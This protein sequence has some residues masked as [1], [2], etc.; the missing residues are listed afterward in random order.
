MVT[1]PTCNGDGRLLD[2]G[3]ARPWLRLCPT[4]WG[5]GCVPKPPRRR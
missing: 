3:S 1:C 4:C 5:L 2:I